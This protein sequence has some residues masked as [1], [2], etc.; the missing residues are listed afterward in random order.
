MQRELRE[1]RFGARLWSALD[2][3]A[4]AFIATGEQLYR[5][6]RADAAFD[7]SAVLMD[8]AKA[9]EVQV[10]TV[11]RAALT[12]VGSSPDLRHENVEGKTVDLVTDGPWT[13]GELERAIGQDEARNTFLKRRLYHGEWFTTQLPPILGELRDARNKAAHVNQ[14]DHETVG[15]LR[16]QLV[17][18]G[19]L[20]WLLELAKVR[21][22]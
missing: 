3:A 7:M 9:M 18:V 20:G 6:H 21:V 10:N 1:N 2:P 14:L 12:G 5:A 15:R 13:L 16:E 4:R 19:C 22:V 17:G 11:L 8:F